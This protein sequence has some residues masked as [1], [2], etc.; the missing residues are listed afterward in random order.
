[1]RWDTQELV[2]AARALA[3]LGLVTAYGHVSARADGHVLITPAADLAGVEV[4]DLVEIPA[5]ATVLPPRAPAESWLHL[6][7][8][9]ARPDL[10]AIARAQ[11]PAAFAAAATTR[12]LR[13]YHGQASW[14]GRAVPVHDDARLL[15]TAELA[16]AAARVL[17]DGEA[18]LLRGNGAVT[19]GASPGLAVARMWLLSTACQVWLSV[20]QYGHGRPLTDAEVASWRAAQPEL[21]PRLWH[22]LRRT[23][24]EGLPS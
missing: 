22:H 19:T 15:R 18:L 23:T 12:E 9:R 16:E 14:L 7:L 1:V 5:D 20:G 24:S 8:Y 10:D 2:D 11:P 6:C 3:G 21:L 4:A 17:T 13:P